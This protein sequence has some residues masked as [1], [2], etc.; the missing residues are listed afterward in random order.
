MV[1]SQSGQTVKIKPVYIGGIVICNSLGVFI[2]VGI[3]NN[4]YRSAPRISAGVAESLKLRKKL[5]VYTSFFFQFPCRTLLQS[6]A[7]FCKTARKRPTVFKR[8]RTA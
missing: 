3:K 1:K 8:I 7:F 5:T 4:C 6:L 2:N